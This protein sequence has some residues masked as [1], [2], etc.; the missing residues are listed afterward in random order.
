MTAETVIIFQIVPIDRTYEKILCG[1]SVGK[2]SGTREDIS[3]PRYTVRTGVDESRKRCPAV[4]AICYP[5]RIIRLTAFYIGQS[6]Y[7]V[8]LI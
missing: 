1:I 5:S 4:A 7:P 2:R 6:V 3:Y 8:I